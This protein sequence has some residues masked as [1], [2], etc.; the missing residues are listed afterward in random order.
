MYLAKI[1]KGKLSMVGPVKDK[2]LEKKGH[3]TTQTKRYNVHIIH[4]M[5]N[6]KRGDSTPR[7]HCDIALIVIQQTLQGTHAV[8]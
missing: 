1:P 5:M 8:K 4:V 7:R 3:Q 6:E 2:F